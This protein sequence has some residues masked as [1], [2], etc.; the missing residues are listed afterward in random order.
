MCECDWDMEVRTN[1]ELRHF[2]DTLEIVD[3]LQPRNAFFGGRTNAVKLHHMAE[4][5]LKEEIEYIDGTSLY[6][7][8]NKTQE[9]PIGH[10][11][12]IVNHDDQDIHQ[13][14]GGAKVDILPPHELYHPALPYRHKGKLTFPLCQTC[15]EKEMS[16]PLL[17][18]FN[19]CHHTPEQ[20]TLR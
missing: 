8:V 15:V 9:Y 2:L 5:R 10:P 3:P 7:W 11:Q 4:R 19:H 6:P 13:H 20:S 17:E 12:V 16:K 1:E 14:F 18:K